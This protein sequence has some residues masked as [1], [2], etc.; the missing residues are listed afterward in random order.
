MKKRK[1][2][3]LL[4]FSLLL[5]LLVPGAM[6]AQDRQIE[7]AKSYLTEVYGYTTEDM[8]RFV[9]QSDNQGI[10]RY[11]HKDYPQWVYAQGMDGVQ[12]AQSPFYMGN[13][14]SFPGEASVRD[15][16][17]L[18]K[19]HQWFSNWTSAS[20]QAFS[21]V[22]ADKGNIK[23]SVALSLGIERGDITA[24]Q[25]V[26]EFFVSCFGSHELWTIQAGEWRDEVLRQNGL[27]F[28][29][30]YQ[31][32]KDSPVIIRSD[33]GDP[34][35]R[36]EFVHII[37]EQLGALFSNPRL[38]GWQSLGGVLNEI[39]QTN[40][41]TRGV[42]LAAFEKNGQCLL[43]CFNK[44]ADEST[45]EMFPVSE[46]AL[47]RE[48]EVKI[49]GDGGSI[50]M[51]I[52]YTL[53]DGSKEEF[54]VL[55]VRTQDKG[56]LL[57]LESYRH[58][59]EK[60]GYAFLAQNHGSAW[61]IHDRNSEGSREERNQQYRVFG[62]M[63]AYTDISTFPINWEAWN[64]TIGS[65][66][67]RNTAL[68]MGVNLREK[69]TSRSKSLGVMNLGTLAQVLGWEK[70]SASPWLHAR[71]GLKTGYVSG[72]YV[73]TSDIANAHEI[74]LAQPLPVAKA[75]KDLELKDGTGWFG[76]NVTELPAGTKMHVISE[77]EGWLYVVVPRDDIGWLMDTEGAYGYVR[78]EDVVVAAT[79]IQADWT[80]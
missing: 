33:F 5:S 55:P 65:V 9:F 48:R 37:P 58:I 74:A 60:T 49:S 38:A 66:L 15:V 63:D 70:G 27:Q 77:E 50:M 13:Y 26:D 8:D 80:E 2:R 28:E 40:G 75:L 43:V 36:I 39:I 21:E 51:R 31:L 24:A 17:G 3:C 7:S 22:L 41:Q 18:A 6:A 79:A 68:L 25:A 16:L 12:S 14:I 20:M 23:P 57:R 10:L 45:W 73:K 1:M 56:N 78:K 59:D 62:Y 71:I 34:I 53:D 52:T 54:A 72:N 35:S 61:S 11:W 30:A 47:R 69:T 42:G 32:P 44:S 46:H 64:D 19:E 76:G 29:T 4:C 67:P